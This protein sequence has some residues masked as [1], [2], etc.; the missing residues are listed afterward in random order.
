MIPLKY[1][2]PLL[3]VILLSG[4]AANQVQRLNGNDTVVVVEENSEDDTRYNNLFS[5]K[6]TYPVT[7]EGDCYPAIPTVVCDKPAEQCQFT[8]NQHAPAINAG[9]NVRW[10]GHASFLIQ[11]DDGTSVLIDP[12]SEQFDWPVDWAFRLTNGFFRNLPAWPSAQ[13]IE[14]V[15]AIMYSHIHYDHFNKADISQIGNQPDYLVPLGFASHFPTDGYRIWEMSWY[16]SHEINDITVHF[17]P[18]HH[19]SSRIW[20]PYVYE[21][22]DKTLWGGWVLENNGKR[23]FFAGDTGYSAHFKQIQQRYGDMD[24]CLIPIASY[25]HAEHGDWYRHVHTT[26]EDALVAASE[27]G[28]KVMI[29]WG[30]GNA[31]WKM[32]DHSSHSALLRLLHMHD[33]LD[34]NVPLYILN[35]GEQVS[36]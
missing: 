25:Y 9:F 22:N 31:S 23:L 3:L 14:Q 20:V 17:V 28:C 1:F 32:G 21:D 27:L 36:L 13:E 26:P 2:V 8:G 6:Q 29:P 35:E 10:L 11:T 34:S 15:D 33:K 7:C 5:G 4:C 18:A 12:V 30:Y 16:A 24:I 19:F